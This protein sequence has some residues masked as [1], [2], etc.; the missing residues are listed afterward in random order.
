MSTPA[1]QSGTTPTYARTALGVPPSGNQAR[2]TGAVIDRD[3]HRRSQDTLVRGR[4]AH[5][6]E[7]AGQCHQVRGVQG[8]GGQRARGPDQQCGQRRGSPPTDDGELHSHSQ[9][10]E[11]RSQRQVEQREQ[12]VQRR[13]A[14]VRDRQRTQQDRRHHERG[15]RDQ[16]GP[17]G[18]RHPPAVRGLLD[19]PA[20][21]VSTQ[22]A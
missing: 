20:F 8:S 11:W 7:P 15:Q 21:G 5:Q 17:V 19:W 3:D 18:K 13:Y 2:S 4:A 9:Q 12:M 1:S 22:N 6:D 16:P 10:R 14:Q